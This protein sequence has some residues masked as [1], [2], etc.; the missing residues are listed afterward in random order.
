MHSTQLFRSLQDRG[1]PFEAMVYPGAKH[2]LIRQHDG[3]HAYAAIL[4]FFEK[5]LR[6]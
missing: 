2:E 6:P 5:E 1:K 4:R 3:R